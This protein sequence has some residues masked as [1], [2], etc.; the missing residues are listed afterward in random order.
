MAETDIVRNSPCGP[1]VVL[2]NVLTIF[3]FLILHSLGEWVVQPSERKTEEEEDI[4]NNNG[5]GSLGNEKQKSNNKINDESIWIVID[6]ED[7]SKYPFLR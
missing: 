6:K 3:H 2:G 5:N 1:P 4:N 7:N